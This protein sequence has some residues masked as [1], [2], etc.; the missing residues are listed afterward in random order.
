MKV[1]N[2]ISF[3][4]LIILFLSLVSCSDIPEESTVS[5]D[6][7]SEIYHKSNKGIKL[8]DFKK[9]NGFEQKVFGQEGYIIEYEAEVESLKDRMVFVSRTV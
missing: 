7:R 8:I 9:T 2:K 6:F 4:A 5:A 1:Y 3:G